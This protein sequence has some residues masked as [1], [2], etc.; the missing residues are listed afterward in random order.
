MKTVLYLFFAATFAGCCT[1]EP[2]SEAVMVA[3]TLASLGGCAVE[4]C[5][6]AEINEACNV[7]DSTFTEDELRDLCHIFS[8]AKVRELMQGY[9]I[10]AMM[11][12][13]RIREI[14]K[15]EAILKFG[16]AGFQ[17]KFFKNTK[18]GT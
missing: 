8:D 18:K 2:S 14:A 12:D 3:M 5:D 10:N 4:P 16:S 6:T 17:E 11:L 1:T 9:P 7:L 13:A 15:T